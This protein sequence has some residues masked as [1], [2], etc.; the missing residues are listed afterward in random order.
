MENGRKFLVPILTEMNGDKRVQTNKRLLIQNANG[1]EAY[2]LVPNLFD[3]T[4][5]AFGVHDFW[6]LRYKNV[7]G[8]T[9]VQNEIDDGTFAGD[10]NAIMKINP[11]V[12]GES[13]ANQDVVV[14]YGAHFNHH[15]GNNVINSQR[16][17]TILSGDHVVGPELRPVRW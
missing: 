15:D 12:N 8:G 3:G 5:D 1:D 4:V 17:P 16:S 11:F 13:V 2:M 10:P 6:V 14:W 7:V 9:T